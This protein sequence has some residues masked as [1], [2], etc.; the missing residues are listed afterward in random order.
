MITLH[1]VCLN[2]K[3][4]CENETTIL[5][6]IIFTPDKEHSVSSFSILVLAMGEI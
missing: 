2:I 6:G 5:Y 1:I 3:L 4:I